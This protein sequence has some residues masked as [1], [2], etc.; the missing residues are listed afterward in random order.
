MYCWKYEYFIN[1]LFPK[2]YAASKN[3]AYSHAILIL[4]NTR[5]SKS[6]FRPGFH[7]YIIYICIFSF[8][9]PDIQ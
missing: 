7:L 2:K 3:N 6:F 9:V 4:H 8:R 5:I 1:I